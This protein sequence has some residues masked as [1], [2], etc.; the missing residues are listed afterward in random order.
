MFIYYSSL[1]S[2]LSFYL[3]EFIFPNKNCNVENAK[4]KWDK[5]G[6]IQTD[7]KK[8]NGELVYDSEVVYCVTCK[9][10]V[11][12]E[13]KFQVDQHLKITSHI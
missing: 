13:K 10:I 5:I 11:P 8:R 6:L 9:N 3:M 4:I 2:N 12:C 1:I 7:K